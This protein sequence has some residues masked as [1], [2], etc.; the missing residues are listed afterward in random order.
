MATVGTPP[1]RLNLRVVAGEPVDVSIP[2]LDGNDA[3]VLTATAPSW[4]IAAQ[5]RTAYT[6]DTALYEFT[7]S[8]SVGIARIQAPGADTADWA[9]DWENLRNPWDLLVT[10]DEGKPH[11]I[12]S[13][14]VIVYP[15]IT[16]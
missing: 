7:S 15:T 4:E 10:D 1:G 2:V 3:V 14:W 5:I 6:A 13:G 11:V 8:L 9:T 16:R 12:C